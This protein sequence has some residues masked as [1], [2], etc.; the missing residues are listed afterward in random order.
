MD[1]YLSLP[2]NTIFPKQLTFHSKLHRLVSPFA[3]HQITVE[4]ID[5]WIVGEVGVNWTSG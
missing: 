3:Y 4:A 5:I 1:T 2:G